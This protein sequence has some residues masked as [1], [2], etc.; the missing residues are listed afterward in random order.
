LPKL[1]AGLNRVCNWF[2][3]NRDTLDTPGAAFS[4][5]KDKPIR[6]I[7]RYTMNYLFIIENSFNADALVSEQARKKKYTGR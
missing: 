2:I 7:M 4:N 3:A 6:V 1:L 5:F